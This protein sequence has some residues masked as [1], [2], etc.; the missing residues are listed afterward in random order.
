MKK[1]LV[2]YYETADGVCPAED[3]IKGQDIKMRAKIYRMLELLEERGNTLRMPYSEHLE[4]GIFEVRTQVGS[5]IARILYF[6]FV[7]R[8]IILTNGFMKKTQKTLP[9]IIEMAKSIVKTISN[10]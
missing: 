10:T 7:G 6:F 4:D 1:F 5:H 2:A 8:K 3:F 9:D